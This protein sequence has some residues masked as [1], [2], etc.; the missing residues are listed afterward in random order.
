MKII[1]ERMDNSMQDTHIIRSK[2]IQGHIWDTRSDNIQ[3]K[4]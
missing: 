3:L 1:Y 2:E 4:K